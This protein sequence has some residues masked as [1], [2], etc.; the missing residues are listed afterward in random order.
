MRQ[1]SFFPASRLSVVTLPA[2][3][4]R[5]RLV[6]ALGPLQPAG[7][8]SF[9][10]LV[11]TLHAWRGPVRASSQLVARL[12]EMTGCVLITRSIPLPSELIIFAA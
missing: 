4:Y 1:S 2:G 11:D 3:C 7:V 5:V 12:V 10:Q 9:S 6:T 8:V